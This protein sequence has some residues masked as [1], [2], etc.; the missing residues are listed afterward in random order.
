MTP[1][2]IRYAIKLLT[3]LP[4]VLCRQLSKLFP[5][6]SNSVCIG[7]WFGNLYADNSKYL[8][9][10]L[11]EETD[12]DVTW[13]AN[14]K[15]RDVLP[16]HPRLKFAK[17]GTFRATVT[18]LR[19]KF[20]IFCIFHA[21]DLTSLPIDG[22]A[23]CINLWHGIPIKANGCKNSVWDSSCPRGRGMLAFLERT[24]SRLSAG[25]KEWLVVS[26]DNMAEI[27]VRGNPATYRFDRIIPVGTPRNDFLI[28]NKNNK[29]LRLSLRKRLAERL[30]FD[31]GRRIVMYLPTWRASGKNVFCFYAIDAEKRKTVMQILE[32]NNAV[33]IEKHHFHT[34]EAYPVPATSDCSIVMRGEQLQEFDAQERWI[35]ADMLISDYSGAYID[36]GL[37]DCPC[38]H[39]A[40]DI[41]DYSKNDCGLAYNLQDV[42]LGPIACDFD[43]LVMALR[44]ELSNMSFRPAAGFHNLVQYENGDSCRKIVEFMEMTRNHLDA[45]VSG[46]RLGRKTKARQLMQTFKRNTVYAGKRDWIREDLYERS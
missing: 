36:F 39:F 28:H 6:N 32:D 13:I 24:Y 22:G 26:S 4:I 3:L 31:P 38:I 46:W 16:R 29:G 33:L 19:A 21:H 11:L 8:C 10:Y 5:R 1:A 27:Q 37:L 23:I 25:E 20:W 45:V 15:V 42:A 2:P 35:C 43:T 12:F 34:Y 18:L 14:E 17:K 7:A 40:Y 41:D 9:E 44:R 30:G